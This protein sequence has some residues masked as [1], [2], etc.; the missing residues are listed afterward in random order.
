M[1]K[2]L[3]KHSKIS[4]II[5]LWLVFIMMATPLF[6]HSGL[7]SNPKAEGGTPVEATINLGDISITTDS[8]KFQLESTDVVIVPLSTVEEYQYY[9]VNTVKFNC[10]SVKL[11]NDSNATINDYSWNDGTN[12]Y[13]ITGGDVKFAISDTDNLGNYM[14]EA[15]LKSVSDIS[16]TPSQFVGVYVKLTVQKYDGSGNFTDVGS[17]YARVKTIKFSEQI[18]F[19]G[20]FSAK[21]VKS[22]NTDIS[23]TEWYNKVTISVENDDSISNYVKNK[24]IGEIKYGYGTD[25]SNITWKGTAGYVD[26]V[27]KPEI[28]FDSNLKGQ[29][30]VYLGYFANSTDTV[31]VTGVT[32]YEVGSVN[33][34]STVPTI[35]STATG[36]YYSTDNWNTKTRVTADTV[37]RPEN[38]EKYR[39][40]VKASDTGSGIVSRKLYNGITELCDFLYSGETDVYYCDIDTN[41][42]AADAPVSTV[43]SI[44]VTDGAGNSASQNV[45]L[46]K[47]ADT[48]KQD[49]SLKWG[50]D[51]TT[52]L[53]D[54]G[55]SSIVTKE[56]H[57]LK[58][59]ITSY[60]R[61]DRIE[62]INNGNILKTE[63][64][65]GNDMDSFDLYYLATGEIKLPEDIDDNVKYT[66]LKL[67]IYF[68]GDGDAYVE[69]A[70][71]SSMLFDNTQPVF[72][73]ADDTNVD[74]SVSD[75]WNLSQ[76]TMKL[77][78]LSGAG[79]VESE[80]D[81]AKYTI[82]STDYNFTFNSD[83]VDDGQINIS[84][85]SEST[86]AQGTKITLYAKDKAGNER[87]MD[88]YYKKDITVPGFATT[89]GLYL[90][91]DDGVKKS[92]SGIYA[93]GAHS[94][95][96]NVT[97]NATIGKIT[98]QL[99]KDGNDVGTLV[100]KDYQ[101]DVS[102][103]DV[104][105]KNESVALS[106]ML[107]TI[108]EE[109][110]NYSVIVTVYDCAGNSKESSISFAL[111]NYKPNPTTWIEYSTDN[112]T[113]WSAVTDSDCVNASDGTKVY[114]INSDDTNAQYRVKIDVTDKLDVNNAISNMSSVCTTVSNEINGDNVKYTYDINKN[115]VSDTGYTKIS[116]DITDKAGNKE[117]YV[118]V[119]A[120]QAIN[121]A[122]S[123]KAELY[124][125]AG[126]PI[127]Y[128]NP[129]VQAALEA[130]TNKSYYVIVDVSSGYTLVA[131]SITL[132]FTLSGSPTQIGGIDYNS[133]MSNNPSEKDVCGRYHYYKKYDITNTE[134]IKFWNLILSAN[135]TSGNYINPLTESLATILYDKTE[136]LFK[137]TGST[138]EFAFQ[139][140]GWVQSTSG[141]I[142]VTSGDGA[143]GLESKLDKATYRI[144]DATEQNIA[145]SSDNTSAV[146]TISVTESSATTA[147]T[148][149]TVYAKDVAGNETTKYYTV[150]VDANEPEVN[151]VS[152]A[153]NSDITVGNNPLNTAPEIKAVVKD[154][155]TI[156][157]IKVEITYPNGTVK[158]KE[159]NYTE[160]VDA[161]VNG[162]T[163]EVSYTI[164]KLVA[165]AANIP[166][167]TYTV[168][169]VAKD[170]AGNESDAVQKSFRVD[171][172]KPVVT[173]NISSGTVSEKYG[174]Y[175]RSNVGVSFTYKEE[176]INWD[177]VVVTDNGSPVSVTWSSTPD[178]EGRYS[179]TY[180]ASSEGTHT[181]KITA[182]DTA[183]NVADPAKVEFCID[184]TEPTLTT[185]INGGILYTDTTGNLYMTGNVTIDVGVKDTNEDV[186]DLNCQ[187]ILT[188]PDQ[189]TVTGLYNKTSDRRFTFTEEGEY[190][191]N[192]F[193][194]DKAGMK[195]SVRS[196]KFRIDK[197]APELSISG[198]DGGTSADAVTVS[199]GMRESFWKDAE[200]KITIYR[201]PGDGVA[202]SVFK[203]ITVTPT[204]ANYVISEFLSETGVYRFEYTASDRAGHT[205]ETKSE[206][207]VDREAPV[208]KLDGPSNYS[209]T[210]D[211][212]SIGITISDDFYL[213]KKITL[214]GTRTDDAG[215]VSKLDFGDY[216]ETG[217]PTEIAATF[218]EDGIYEISVTATDKAGNS[219][220]AYV[221]FTIDNSAPVIKDMAELD[222]KTLNS[223]NWEEDLDELVSDL[224][225]CDV[226]MY[227]NG[228][229]Y[230]GKS[231]IE[232]GSYTLL[233]IAEDELGNKTEKEVKFVLDTKEPVFIITGVEDGE[234]KN[235]AYNISIS[236]QLDEDKLTSVTL[237]GEVIAVSGN[238]CQIDVAEKGTYKLVMT[239]TDEAGNTASY[240]IEFKYGEESNWWIWLIIA[241][242]AVIVVGI[243]I[244]ILVK[245]KNDKK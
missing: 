151:S 25:T 224:T 10:G 16:A 175:Y 173:S 120:V 80:L 199:F 58:Y 135:D 112:G 102:L 118:V 145:M 159:F 68:D 155:L 243:I 1:K 212:V 178:S 210:K 62:I 217:N 157:N 193:A 78:I 245:K 236:L 188:K 235:E 122:L 113:N 160:N 208:V 196:V 131:D 170:L 93:N 143:A 36:L 234:V 28:T 43:Y 152:V 76:D 221:Y 20:R 55:V 174:T 180:V 203:T 130:G 227:L 37:I 63:S 74:F 27:I 32:P 41:L 30:K 166:D 238:S 209:K 164:E 242:A 214:V 121:K 206:I 218:S 187:V 4:K 230:D 69:K 189:A 50:T 87:T 106:D 15:D 226:Q 119:P 158:T 6:S 207:V 65:S 89:D 72:A 12:N 204:S 165:D 223:F 185:M 22:D 33:V 222:G 3:N 86:S 191:I 144:G 5:A 232:D 198:V 182:E 132:S 244:I 61:L 177:K 100:T 128:T 109:N 98:F 216:S 48:T 134:N 140:T 46:L 205:S 213:Q 2:I 44:K 14:D 149:V 88:V 59:D 233:I 183:G 167:G 70:I 105:E 211:P 127:D 231:D 8:D 241:I 114:Y 91:G 225:V 79:S 108:N 194:I 71:T 161:E 26:S 139:G 82:D 168:K 184:K 237:N 156:S 136:P 19:T 29:Y 137:Q 239:A 176:N 64:N 229:E 96:A 146:G 38:K 49:I 90:V 7:L 197:S 195:S 126:N 141:Y 85:I 123:I 107:D 172:T 202:E 52:N 11:V 77:D 31:P 103:Y 111:D 99:K 228:S 57:K 42:A 147:G 73:K 13:K 21:M 153:G 53:P 115:A 215:K 148:T 56:Q 9:N 104:R 179:A 81:T 101:N 17:K 186:G 171:T 110:G 154:N 163:K 116:F 138:N 84:N 181:I 240:E 200:G 35:D 125:A 60:K 150:K 220:N 39:Y 51:G 47:S 142:T 190:V 54:E 75:T 66:D 124:D 162:G 117:S 24:A 34:D 192:F 95:V 201:K 40:Y 133:Q 23:L 219:D 94:V 169:V 67:K 97:D 45:A 92:G 18:P 83:I 129:G